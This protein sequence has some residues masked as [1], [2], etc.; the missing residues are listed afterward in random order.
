VE[1][2]KKEAEKKGGTS[3]TYNPKKSA[4]GAPR[5]CKDIKR[6][7]EGRQSPRGSAPRVGTGKEKTNQ[8]KEVNSELTRQGKSHS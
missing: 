8:N 1:V 6:I 4:K 5:N 3:K 7:E 2:K